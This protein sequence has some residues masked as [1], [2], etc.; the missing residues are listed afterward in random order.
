MGLDEFCARHHHRTRTEFAHDP[1]RRAHGYIARFA[2]PR[3][4]S[5]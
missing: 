1:W 2:D 4:G 5:R 3:P